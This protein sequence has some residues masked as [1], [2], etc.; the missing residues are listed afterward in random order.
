MQERV[1]E[2]VANNSRISKERFKDFMLKTGEIANDVG[3]VLFGQEAVDIGIID[4]IGGISDAIEKI[5][6][7]KEVK[8]DA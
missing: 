6:E 7:L 2:F 8:G 5:K 1:V 3:T 4:S